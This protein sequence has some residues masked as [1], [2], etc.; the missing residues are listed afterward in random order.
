MPPK[1]AAKA[2][3][4]DVTGKVRFL[5]LHG[6]ERRLQDECLENLRAAL[7]KAHGE[8]GFDTVRFDAMQGGAKILA[9]VLD[10][11]RSM[12]LMSQYKIVLVE[13]ADL[14]FKGEE[15]E[16]GG[17]GGG[18][19]V[20]PAGKGKGARVSAP[21]SPREVL[22]HYAAQPEEGATLVLRCNIWRG[23]NL[24]KAIKA[25]E[26]GR[27][28]VVKCEPMNE[29]EATRWA[30]ARAKDAHRSSIDAK[31]AALLVESV[32]AD[33]GR[34]DSELEKLAVAAGGKGQPITGALVQKMTGVT[35]EDEF[36]TIQERLLAGDGPGALAQL[37][38]LL[39]ISR[40]DP[41]PI[42]WSCVDAAKKLHTI[43]RGLSQ[44]ASRGE[45]MSALRLWGP[46]VETLFR[47]AQAVGPERAARMLKMAVDTD[48]RGKSGFGEPERN[49]ELLVL[50][51]TGVR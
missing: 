45:L 37:R 11:C 33:L 18:G 20:K 47:R 34:I 35:R 13:N 36:W 5:V 44:G 21:S 32:G 8:D 40:H 7:K 14:L 23:G 1:A 49:L 38:E 41:V 17:G 26:G 10:E 12:G 9:D 16:G 50:G 15:D 24:E 42:T 43:S 27:G 46:S 4:S 28:L 30:V 48:A 31:A 29:V 39:E 6:K 22:E 19:A 51:M 3:P 2:S 25:L